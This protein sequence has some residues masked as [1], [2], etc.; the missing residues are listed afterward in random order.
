MKR[1]YLLDQ[2]TFERL[3]TRYETTPDL[4]RSPSRAAVLARKRQAIMYLMHK[5]LKID[6]TIVARQM[7]RDHSTVL[8]G[9]EQ[10][11]KRMQL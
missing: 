4:M 3:C 9:A 8:Y 2:T 6:S 10:H 11:E 7:N 5:V 1:D